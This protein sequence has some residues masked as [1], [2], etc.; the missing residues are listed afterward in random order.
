MRRVCTNDLTAAEL[1]AVTTAIVELAEDASGFPP[2][3]EQFPKAVG[4]KVGIVPQDELIGDVLN[5]LQDEQEARWLERQADLLAGW[6]ADG[7]LTA[8]ADKVEAFAAGLRE[9]AR[10]RDLPDA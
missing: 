5:A 4:R 2:T 10:R 7:S 3:R 9:L 6:A 8:P 1:A